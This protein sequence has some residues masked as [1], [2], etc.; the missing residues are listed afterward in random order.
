MDETK[1]YLEEDCEMSGQDLSALGKRARSLSPTGTEFT[2]E[3]EE[4]GYSC[5]ECGEAFLIRGDS[6]LSPQ[7]VEDIQR[8]SRQRIGFGYMRTVKPELCRQPAVDGFSHDP[9]P[10]VL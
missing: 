5:P 3:E 2:E 4:V 8:V 10:D 6:L 7:E 1:N 9:K